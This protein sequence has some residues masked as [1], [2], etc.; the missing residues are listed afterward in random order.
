MDYARQQRDP[1]KHAIGIAFVVATFIIYALITGLARTMVEVIETALG[2]DHRGNQTVSP[3]PPPP[4]KIVE[5]PKKAPVALRSAAR[6]SGSPDGG[7][8]DFSAG[9]YASPAPYGGKPVVVEAPPAPPPKPVIRRALRP[10]RKRIRSIRN[11]H[12]RWHRPGRVVAR[13]NIDERATS[14]ASRSSPPIR[15]SISTRRSSTR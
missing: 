15:R 8:C 10:S 13:L 11:R 3:P 14:R 12:R 5:T 6:Y 9:L 4:K 7:A 1:A 2:D